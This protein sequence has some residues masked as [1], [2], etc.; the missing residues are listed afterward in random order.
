MRDWGYSPSPDELEVVAV[1]LKVYRDRWA[2]LAR[3]PFPAAFDG[4]M[5]DVDA[6]DY[7]NYEGIDV[8]GGGLEPAAVVCGEVLRRAAGLEWVI[9]YR[10]D[11]FVASDE[12]LR[13][14]T[15][16][17]LARLHEIECGGDRGAGMY[18]RF[19]QK[20]AFDC[21]L[22]LAAEEERRAREL[23]ENGGDYLEYVERT[24]EKLRRPSPTARRKKHHR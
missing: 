23:I 6:L 3:P 17:P 2:S 14:I 18:T 8:P 15:I 16:C 22:L 10:G 19:V 11:W 12:P 1:A 24:L 5:D 4:S 7:M 20:A 13:E 9:S 21:L